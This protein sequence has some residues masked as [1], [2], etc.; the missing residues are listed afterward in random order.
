MEGLFD[1]DAYRAQSSDVAALLVLSHQTRMTNLL[2]RASWEARAVDPTLHPPFVATPQAEASIA[3]MMSGVANEVVDYLLFIDEAKL[4]DRVRGS[5]GF[6][7]RFSTVGPRDRKGRSLHELDLN[8]RLMK[9]PCSYL[10]YSG[11]VRRVAAGREGPHLQ[12]HVAGASGEER[13]PR[14][15][16]ALSLGPSGHRRNPAR[17]QE[18]PSAVFS[19]CDQVADARPFLGSI[20]G[21]SALQCG[22]PLLNGVDLEGNSDNAESHFGFDGRP[23]RC[24]AGPSRRHICPEQLSGRLADSGLG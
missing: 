18:R 21:G 23:L 15:R 16:S 19:E 4:A 9:Y 12:A 10:I 8:R 14:Y 7:E 24:G 11:G 1:S 3:A 22:K 5:T 13:D 6:A 20:T 2:T 17:Y